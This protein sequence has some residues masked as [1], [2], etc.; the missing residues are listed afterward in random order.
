MAQFYRAAAASEVS[1]GTGKTVTLE[2]K[3]IAL[4][5]VNG[6]FHAIDNTCPHRQGPLG[7]GALNGN[8]VSCPWHGWNFDV[9]NGSC[10]INPMVKVAVY[11][12]KVEG[13]SIFVQI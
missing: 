5:N 8:L 1:P 9:T 11:S 13:D 7:E 3:S 12:T 6:S 10:R 4:F 2:G